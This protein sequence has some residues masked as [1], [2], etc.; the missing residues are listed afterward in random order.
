MAQASPIE[1]TDATP[2]VDRD[3]RRTRFY[4]RK[5]PNRPG[6][7]L[8]RVMANEGK[9]WC[10]GCRSWLPADLIRQGACKAHLASEYRAQYAQN[11]DAIRA[12]SKARKRN[13]EPVDPAV[14]E[15]I[16]DLFDGECAYCPRAANTVDHIEPVSKGGSSRLGNVVPACTSC[17]SRKRDTDLDTF[18]LGC[19]RVHFALIN[20]IAMGDIL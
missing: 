20:E 6:Q 2:I 5:D 13:A 18:V 14:R 15:T 11:P 3:G 17:N 9:A 16:F 12:R 4:K 10:R 19:E 7:Q 8:R 1:W